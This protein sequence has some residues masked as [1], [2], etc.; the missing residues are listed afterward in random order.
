V[1][2]TAALLLCAAELSGCRSSPPPRFY[3]LSVVK[4]TAPAEGLHWAS[5]GP[6]GAAARVR[7]EQLRLPGEL[8]RSQLVRRIDANRLQVEADSRWA[9]P[10][11]EMIRRVLSTNLAARLPPGTV[12]DPYQPLPEGQVRALTV[13]VYEFYGDGRCAVSLGATWQLTG[14]RTRDGPAAAAQGATEEVQVAPM[15][16]CPGT[17]AAAMSQALGGLADRMAPA[18]ARASAAADR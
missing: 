1:K 11:D 4:S 9:A 10:L 5:P 3:V 16:P 14:P 15:G 12:A 13:D 2:R 17:L 8:D 18:I 6:A 7:L